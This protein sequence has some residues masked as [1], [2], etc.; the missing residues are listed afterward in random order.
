MILLQ[1]IFVV[2]GLTLFI[3]ALMEKWN[4]WDDIARFGSNSKSKFFYQLTTCRFC[5]LSHIG[6]V[7]TCIV[8][9]FGGLSVSWSVLIVPMVVSGFIHLILNK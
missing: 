1:T 7:V 3:N 6:L 5:L 9:I 4:L 8:G 2:L